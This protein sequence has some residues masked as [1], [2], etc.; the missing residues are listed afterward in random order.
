[1]LVIVHDNVVR[2]ALAASENTRTCS[3][4]QWPQYPTFWCR[5]SPANYSISVPW[6]P[7]SSFSSKKE[8]CGTKQ[9]SVLVV[10]METTKSL[11]VVGFFR[12]RR[13]VCTALSTLLQSCE[14][15]HRQGVFLSNVSK[16]NWNM[17]FA[18]K[19]SLQNST[20]KAPAELLKCHFTQPQDP[21]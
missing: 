2:L 9:S 1:M 14:C 5:K 21:A 13:V 3:Q 10:G 18:V 15:W 4:G 6:F 16:G 20:M 17:D 12:F 11:A 19:I 8:V 7:N